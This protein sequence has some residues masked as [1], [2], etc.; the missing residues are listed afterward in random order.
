MKR[1]SIYRFSALTLNIAS[2]LFSFA[3]SIAGLFFLNHIAGY[4][5]GVGFKSLGGKVDLEVLV[6]EVAAILI[7]GLFVWGIN[8]LIE[9]HSRRSTT[10]IVVACVVVALYIT[11]I[12]FLIT[13][14]L[15]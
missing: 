4:F 15:A 10:S 7:L 13:A 8:S 5:F 11:P 2:G 3:A 6:V 1:K 12:A 14:W 9:R